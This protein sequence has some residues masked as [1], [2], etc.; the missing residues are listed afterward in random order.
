MKKQ[1][2]S[3]EHKDKK[4]KIDYSK[5]DKLELSDDESQKLKEWR[6]SQIPPPVLKA[7]DRPS[8]VSISS[9]G[10]WQVSTTFKTAT[11]D[12]KQ[13]D[14]SRTLTE[15]GGEFVDKETKFRVMWSQDRYEVIINLVFDASIVDTSSVS[16]KLN[17]AVPFEHRS[18]AGWDGPENEDESMGSIEITAA[19]RQDKNTGNSLLTLL[20]G[21][22]PHYVYLD[23]EDDDEGNF[24]NW[25]IFD[26]SDYIPTSHEDETKQKTQKILRVTLNKA[27]SK[28]LQTIWWNRLL[29]HSQTIH[30]I[31]VP[32]KD[33]T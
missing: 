9:D 2:P 16:V 33:H 21:K 27:V 28:P 8:S 4:R 13:K 17:G 23:E 12:N 20:S 24:V 26:C 6:A 18:C 5:W 1:R 30:G 7:S 22:F 3:N 29:E 14:R 19:S 31:K 11:I 10:K 25:S 32:G 15:N